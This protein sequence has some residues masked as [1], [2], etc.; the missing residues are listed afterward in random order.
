MLLRH[1]GIIKRSYLEK[2][3]LKKKT[4]ESL[5]KYKKQEFLL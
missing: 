3:Y 4:T 2:L 1:Y 5:R